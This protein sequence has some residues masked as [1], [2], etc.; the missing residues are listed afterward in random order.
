LPKQILLMLTLILL[1]Q[2]F[3]AQ[4]WYWVS[5]HCYGGSHC[6]RHSSNSC[7]HWYR[8]HTGMYHY[9]CLF[10]PIFWLYCWDFSLT[11]WLYLW[12]Q[13]NIV[14]C[15]ESDVHWLC[16]L[17]TSQGRGAGDCIWAAERQSGRR[18]EAE[19]KPYVSETVQQ[20]NCRPHWGTGVGRVLILDI[21]VVF[22]TTSSCFK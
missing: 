3:E 20:S 18:D 17:V 12:N 22:A 6:Q 11:Q 2:A 5:G 14:C 7:H 15:M 13:Y 1:L 9:L 16:S 19:V 4:Q 10:Y 21:A 8:G